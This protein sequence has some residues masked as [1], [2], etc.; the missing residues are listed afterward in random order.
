MVLSLR[1]IS[2][3][4]LI[5][6]LVL[7]VSPYLPA[8]KAQAAPLTEASIRL[9]RMGAS[10][11]AN[12]T[13]AKILVVV[14]PA[15]TAT[16]ANFKITWPDSTANAFTVDGTAGNHTTSTTGLPATYHGE[17]LSSWPTIG[18]TASSVTDNG[19]TTD[20]EYSSGDL[21]AG[22]LYGFWITGGITNPSNGNAGT[23]SVILTTETSGPA[24][25]D[26]QTVAV[27]TV[28]TNSDQVTLT[29]SV[30]PS[31]N[32]ALSGSSIALGTLSTSARST[33]N[34]TVDVDTNANNGW[35]AW[36]RSEG[37]AATL[38]SASTSD[39]ISSTNTGSC[40][41]ATIGSKGY[42]VDVNAVAGSNAGG[43]LTVAT[44]YD[45]TDNQAG[46]VISTTY[47][48]IAD[49]TG[50]VDSDTLTLTA[51]VT[52]SPTTKAATDYTDTW[53]VVGAGDF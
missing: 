52:I 25:I 1:K 44:E 35:I 33:G 2:I 42:V 50:V 46:G 37:A 32:F 28:G 34:V 3:V 18:A 10:I 15:S 27:D 24:A 6:I 9:D 29:A 14:K 19:N 39:S 22:T 36:M 5:A 17:A 16:E 12:G 30:D 40:V 45:C 41:T 7:I 51:V 26:T 31:F 4:L 38:A 47:E 53:E 23:K 48:Q 43:A 49:R 13:N 20:V 21:T 11:A 8:N